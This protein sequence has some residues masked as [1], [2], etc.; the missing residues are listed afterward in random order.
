[1]STRNPELPNTDMVSTI[2][3][4]RRSKSIMSSPVCAVAPMGGC[5]S[6][7]VDGVELRSDRLAG[8]LDGPR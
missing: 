5:A 3:V 1:M 6:F 7:V 4:V 8:D 2:A